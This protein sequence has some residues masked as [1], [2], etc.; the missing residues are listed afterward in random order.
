MRQ[1][2]PSFDQDWANERGFYLSRPAHFA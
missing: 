2:L 1:G